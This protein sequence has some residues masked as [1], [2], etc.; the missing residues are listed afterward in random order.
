MPIDQS[1]IHQLTDQNT[2]NTEYMRNARPN[3]EWPYNK[4]VDIGVIMLQ[5]CLFVWGNI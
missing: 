5:M 3:N 2:V 1:I 4:C